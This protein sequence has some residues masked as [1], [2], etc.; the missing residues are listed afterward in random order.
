MAQDRVRL[1]LEVHWNAFNAL[2]DSQSGANEALIRALE[3]FE[4]EEI[5]I[6]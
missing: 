4:G 3:V 5:L 2:A 6:F 1:Q